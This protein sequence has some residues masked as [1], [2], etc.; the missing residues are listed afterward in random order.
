M[1]I[2]PEFAEIASIYRADGPATLLWTRMIAD[3][4]TPVSTFLKL[5]DGEPYCCLFESVEG[6]A[7]IGRYSIIALRPD[8]I[9]RAR[10]LRPEIN[11]A[12][13]LGN[14]AFELDDRPALDSLRA[15]LAESRIEPPPGL[16]PMTAGGLF[17]YLGYDMVRVVEDI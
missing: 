6:G 4:E 3:L 2:N 15:I 1:S 11:R 17:G 16:P 14:T 9:W 13:H 5:A 8:L 12:P 7:N 10:D